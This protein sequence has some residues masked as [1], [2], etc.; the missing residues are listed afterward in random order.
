MDTSRNPLDYPDWPPSQEQL[1][2]ELDIPRL[3]EPAEVA[4]ACLFFALD[5]SSYITGQEVHV[6]GGRVKP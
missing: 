3:G 4:D 6:N 2:T 5:Q 1:A